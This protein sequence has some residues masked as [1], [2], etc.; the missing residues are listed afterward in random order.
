MYE[1]GGWRFARRVVFRRRVV[2]RRNG[3]LW[4]CRP[5]AEA[6]ET[7]ALRGVFADLFQNCDDDED[8]QELAGDQ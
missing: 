3:G 5:S 6:G 7:P 1:L 4:T 8:C 2:L